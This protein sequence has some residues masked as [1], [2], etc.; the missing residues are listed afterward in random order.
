MEDTTRTDIRLT[1]EAWEA[2]LT[3]HA[4]LMG[5]YASE[6]MWTD[7]S[8]REYDVLYTLSKHRTPLRISE[9]QSGVL[10]SQPALSRMV[11]RL[12]S[13][14]LLAREADS[15]DGRAVRVSLTEQGAR[16]QRAVGRAHAKSV[17]HEIGT[18]LTRDEIQDLRRICRKLAGG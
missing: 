12:V 2:M 7:V 16:V 3:A 1:N 13:R 11:E 5:V 10:L 6:N 8:M 17:A 4:A 9:I 15:E 14:G 18:A